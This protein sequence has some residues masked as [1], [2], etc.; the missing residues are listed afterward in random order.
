MVSLGVD[1]EQSA[2]NQEQRYHEELRHTAHHQ[3]LLRFFGIGTGQ[4]ALHHILVEAG[5]GNHHEHAGNKL[6]PEVGAL[7]G[8]VEEEHSRRVVVGHGPAH[9][10]QVVSQPLGDKEDAQHHTHY[11]AEALQRVGPYHGFHTTLQGVEEYER[12][13][14][15]HVT[16][17]WDAQRRENQQL[18]CDTHHIEA[19]GRP[20][21]L[22]D[23]EEPRATLVGGGSEPLLQIAVD[24]YE[25]ATIEERNQHVGNHKVAH[26]ET[27][28]HPQVAESL[29]QHHSGHR[30]K[31]YARDGR[32]YHGDGHNEPRRLATS[33][34]SGVIVGPA[35]CRPRDQ[36]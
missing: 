33:G 36:E 11:Q 8:I 24:G 28:C 5:G 6:L 25:F 30:H 26:D 20:Q 14:H 1:A 4:S 10:G 27:Q 19:H 12:Y 17:K 35:A 21:H 2:Q 34:E 7:L 16:H 31:R 18:Q 23:E 13:G 9:S 29:A 15:G 32:A 22:A 3:A